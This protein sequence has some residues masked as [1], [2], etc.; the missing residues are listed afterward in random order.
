MTPATRQFPRPQGSTTRPS[1][2]LRRSRTIAVVVTCLGPVF[3]LAPAAMADPVTVISR[4]ADQAG[5]ANGAS[6]GLSWDLNGRFAIF[7]SAASNLVSGQ[8]TVGGAGILNLFLYDRLSGTTKLVN[9]VPGSPTIGASSGAVSPAI[10]ADGNW[11]VYGSLATNL[12]SGQIDSNAAR[13]VFLWDRQTDTTLLVTHAVGS[14]ITAADATSTS[15][16]QGLSSDGCYV[17]F[18]S[19]A[20]NLVAGQTANAF[21]QI[22]QFD[23]VTGLNAMVSHAAGGGATAASA[24]SE[25][26]S[27]SADGRWIVFASR[28]SNL[29]AG[30]SDSNGSFDVFLWD[31]DATFAASTRLVS[32]KQG[33]AATTGNGTSED[34]SISADGTGVAFNSFASDLEGVTSDTN[35]QAD[36]FHYDRPTDTV[37]LVSHRFQLFGTPTE[38]ADGFVNEPPSVSH[39]GDTVAFVS[40]STDHVFQQDDSNGFTDVFLWATGGI[41]LASHVPG[42]VSGPR[43][44]GDQPSKRA[45]VAANGSGVA[46]SSRAV[47][48]VDGVIDSINTDD[49]FFFR[50][51][52]GVVSLVSH[53]PDELQAAGAG[54]FGSNPDSVALDGKIIGFSSSSTLLAGGDDN[55]VLDVFFH[56]PG[57]VLFTDG[58]ESGGLSPWSLTVP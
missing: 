24:A 31:R 41:T 47:N 27:I 23:R 48:L 40:G 5:T 52:S 15:A 8:N 51:G 14:A 43:T 58:L 3:A 19:T 12:V 36:T 55:G 42:A 53:G 37:R 39:D 44:T 21:T 57:N 49:V 34:P 9:H 18:H 10:S 16:Q 46:F 22:Y 38:T 7:S 2:R 35:E 56:A 50:R 45:I 4:S 33:L 54:A 6:Q 20:S 11:V 13:D 30:L 26:P 28:A 29:V 1:A 17:T 25:K 32:R